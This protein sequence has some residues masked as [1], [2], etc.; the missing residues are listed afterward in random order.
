MDERK[1]SRSCQCSACKER[2][3]SRG[4]SQRQYFGS[5]GERGEKEPTRINVEIGLP[6]IPSVELLQGIPV[7]PSEAGLKGLTG[8]QGETGPQGVPG[9]TGEIGPPGAT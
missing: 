6:G 3:N 8:I 7:I 5:Q 2:R 4:S 1:K 9:I